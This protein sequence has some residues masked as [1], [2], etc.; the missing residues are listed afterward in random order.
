MPDIHVDRMTIR[1][2]PSRVAAM[3]D[4]ELVATIRRQF[5]PEVHNGDASDL[6]AQR[7][8]REVRSSA[9]RAGQ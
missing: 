2:D 4:A 8:A 5:P 6:L 7:V 9:R 3:T 1:V